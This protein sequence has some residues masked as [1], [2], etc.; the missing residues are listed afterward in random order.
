M[1]GPILILVLVITAAFLQAPAL[2]H[3]SII[4]GTVNDPSDAAIVGASVTL[5][6]TNGQTIL[7][8][9]TDGRGGFR[10]DN[11]LPGEYRLDIQKDGFVKF[12]FR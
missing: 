2:A 12:E 8:T 3:A 7:N 9:L 5:M 1:H 10:F 11:V 6:G 4:T